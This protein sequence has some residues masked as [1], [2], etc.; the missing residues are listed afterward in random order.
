MREKY[1]T[2]EIACLLQIA[3]DLCVE[4]FNMEFVKNGCKKA[5]RLM[6]LYEFDII[7]KKIRQRMDKHD[8]EKLQEYICNLTDEMSCY[9]DSM[10][11][12]FLED[13]VKKFRYQSCAPLAKSLTITTIMQCANSI[14]ILMTK[15]ES[16]RIKSI[17]DRMRKI[18]GDIKIS[19][20][21]EEADIDT[22]KAEIALKTFLNTLE[23]KS[24]EYVD[25]YGL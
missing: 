11:N 5:D 7:N 14:F 10:Y 16:G 3:Q 20:L 21:N 9:V 2:F 8:F 15:G 6:T 13:A 23:K 19:A 24:I 1:W 18:G 17:M 25:K 12:S 4:F 22:T